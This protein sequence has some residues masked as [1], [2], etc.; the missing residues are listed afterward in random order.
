MAEAALG[1]YF[2]AAN[3]DSTLKGEWECEWRR[4]GKMHKDK[5]MQMHAHMYFS[6]LV[7]HSAIQLSLGVSL[8]IFALKFGN[9]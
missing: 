7:S 8:G 3:A 4:P 5:T 9:Q 2:S 6:F 1:H